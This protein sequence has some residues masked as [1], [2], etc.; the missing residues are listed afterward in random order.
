[1]QNR[2]WKIGEPCFIVDMSVSDNFARMRVMPATITHLARTDGSFALATS[3]ST[4]RLGPQFIEGQPFA[5][6]K[7]AREWISGYVDRVYAAAKAAPLSGMEPG[8]YIP[9]APKNG[10]IVYGIDAKAEQVFEAQIGFVRFELGRLE[11][12]YDDSENNVRIKE[13]WSSKEEA[14]SEAHKRHGKTF[15]FVPAAEVVRRAKAAEQKIWDDA[16]AHMKKPESIEGMKRLAET[17]RPTT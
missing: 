14:L 5:S 8:W 3:Y 4:D 12:G 9:P 17:L 1:M 15:A 16:A 10:D 7:E 6:E 2:T 11:V 13:W